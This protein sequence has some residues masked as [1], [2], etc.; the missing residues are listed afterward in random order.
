MPALRYCIERVLTEYRSATDQSLAQHPMAEFIGRDA[1]QAVEDALAENGAGLLIVGRAGIGNWATV[2]WISVFDRAITESA[3]KGYYPVY[4]FHSREQ[5]VHLSLNQGTTAVRREFNKSAR[6]IMR[7]RADMMRARIADVPT[8]FSSTK[9]ELGSTKELPR[10][11]EAAHVLGT[12]YHLRTLPSEETL[13]S[14][15]QTMVRLYRTLT[16]RGGLDASL[17]EEVTTT[18][19]S[20]AIDEI[21]RYRLHR[22]IERNRGASERAKE[23]HG[24]RCQVCDIDFGEQYGVLG[25][26]FIEAH[27][28][29]PL[30]SLQEGEAVSYSLAEDFAVLCSNCH[31]M[32]HRWPDPADLVGFR[33][34]VRVTRKA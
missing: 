27:H 32:I 23:Y 26:G 30:S 21:R 3:T 19:T 1:K 6:E 18:Q 8:N 24:T 14:D 13:R 25:K 11:Y 28:L 34:H 2:P 15:L 7:Q 33:N 9:I 29:H 16:F 22:R 17:D 12:T 10:D 5:I 4:L 20:D 31:R